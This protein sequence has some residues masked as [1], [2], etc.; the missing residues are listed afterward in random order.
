[1]GS[2]FGVLLPAG[3]C[4][5]C[6]AT[7]GPQT[8]QLLGSVVPMDGSLIG[9]VYRSGEPIMVGDVQKTSGTARYAADATAAIHSWMAVPMLTEHGCLGVLVAS[10]SDT[11]LYTASHLELLSTLADHATIALEKGDLLQEAK[12]QAAEQAALA[13]SANAIARL[14]VQAVLHTIA[15]QASKIVK[16][17]RCSVFLYEPST[18]TL[19]WA[20]G[21]EAVHEVRAEQFPAT[22]GLMGHVFTTTEPVLVDDITVDSRTSARHLLDITG[23]RSFLCVPLRWGDETMGVLL[24]THPEVGVFTERD[25]ELISTFAD[26]A[27]IALSNA[28]LY[29]SL[30]HREEE[31]TFL[32]HQMMTAQEAERRRVAVDIHDGPLQSIGVNMLAVDRIRKLMD[33]GRAT[34]AMQELVQVRQGMSSVVQELRDVINELRPVVLENLGLLAA[35][36]AQLNYLREQTG[37]KTH[38]EENLNGFRLPHHQEVIFFRLLQEALTNVRKH[39]NAEAVWVSFSHS[40]SEFHMNVTDN[41]IGFDPKTIVRSLESGHIGLHSMQE[42]IEAVGGG[43]EI[44]STEGR[45]TRITFWAQA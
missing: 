43:M 7:C 16:Q 20:A 32:L 28:R 6:V 5:S 11:N 10:H 15:T 9:K 29:S 44:D 31:R 42:R 22:A 45:G 39:A 18:D 14:D 25:L 12:K 36:G 24:T 26:Y 1:M 40:K 41:G 33:L 23:T 35:A 27:S 37:I 4:L 13:E 8:E 19:K 3:D 17:S 30:Q 2:Q 38:L 21:E 34:D